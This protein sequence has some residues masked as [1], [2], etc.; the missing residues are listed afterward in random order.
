MRS[1]ATRIVVLNDTPTP[2]NY[3]LSLHDALPIC[4]VKFTASRSEAF[5]SDYQG[6]DLVTE[7]ELA[8][9]EI[10]EHTSELQSH[11]DLVCRLLLEKKNKVHR[12]PVV[13]VPLLHR[14]DHRDDQR[15]THRE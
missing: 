10:G 13:Q 2:D 7:V 1:V 3:T 11:H 4:P 12:P 14:D 8:L 5:L 15:E 9:R 6:R